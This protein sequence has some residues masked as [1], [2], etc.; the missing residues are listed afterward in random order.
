M[1]EISFARFRPKNVS[2]SNLMKFG[3]VTN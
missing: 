1:T 2:S 3:T